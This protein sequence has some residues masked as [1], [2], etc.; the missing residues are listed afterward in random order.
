MLDLLA[1]LKGLVDDPERFNRR[2][3]RVDELREKVQWTTRPFRIINSATQLAELRRYSAD[4]KLQT[5]EDDDA[6]RA[7]RQLD[8]D[9]EFVSAVRDGARTVREMLDQAG[10]R[11]EE[12]QA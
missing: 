8:R 4:R 11:L 5:A 1:Q 3:V 7:R 6:E 9:V 12:A 2:L 10:T